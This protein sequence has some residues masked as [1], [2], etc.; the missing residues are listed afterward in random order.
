MEC[1]SD[2]SSM[3]IA[4]VTHLEGIHGKMNPGNLKTIQKETKR[5]VKLWRKDRSLLAAEL[6]T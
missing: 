2:Y 3:K 6:N 5:L 1:L 4:I